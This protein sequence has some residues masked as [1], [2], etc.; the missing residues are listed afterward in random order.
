MTVGNGNPH[1]S[2][3]RR[4]NCQGWSASAVRRNLQFL[5]QVDERGLEN[6]HGVALTLTVRDC[7]V[8]AIEW[9]H[10]RHAFLEAMRRLGAC[11]IHWV[12]EWQ[13]RGVP[14]LHLAVYFPFCVPSSAILAHWLRISSSWGSQYRGQHV[15]PIR[16]VLG[17]NQYVSKHAARGLHHYQRSAQCLPESWRGASTGRMWGKLGQWPLQPQVKIEFP[18]AAFHKFRRMVRAWRVADAR[19]PFRIRNGIGFRGSLWIVNGRRVVSARGML[20]CPVPALSAV[21]G[22]SEWIPE[23]VTDKLLKWLFDQGFNLLSV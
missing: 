1:P 3:S 11:L 12:T 16:D 20:R 9:G 10:A 17:W 22:V 5:Y 23:S 6:F 18:M 13:A 21:R 19:R 7:P 15:T 8:T 2:P 4:S 14:H